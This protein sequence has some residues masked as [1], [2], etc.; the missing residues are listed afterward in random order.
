M[1]ISVAAVV[2]SL[3][4][5]GISAFG[6]GA[7]GT[8]TG[9]VTDSTGAVVPGA[10]IEVRN[11]ATGQVYTGASSGTGNFSIVQLPTGDYT[12]TVRGQGFKTFTH[13]N[14][15]LE[16]EAT[17]RQDATLQVGAASDT[18]TVAAEASLLTTES[19]EMATNVSVGSLDNLPILGIGPVNS[20][21]YGLRNPWNMM[22]FVGGVGSYVN[23]A[24]MVI[25]GLGGLDNLTEEMRIEGQDF[26]NHLDNFGTQ[27]NA[28]S[29]DAIQEV[30]VQTSN[31]AAEYGTAGAAVLNVTMKSGTNAFH[32]SAYDYFVN[33]DLNAG[34]PF[35][36]SGGPSSNPGG[37]L[38]KYRPRNRRND[39]GGTFGGPVWIPKIYN[40]R[41][42]TFFFVNFEQFR[43]T[44]G[45][46][47]GLTVPQPY[48]NA[49]DFSSISP[50]GTCSLCS[51]Y[52]IPTG[53]LGS[54]TAAKDPLGRTLLANTIYDPMT[55]GVVTSS[56]LGYA[57][58]F[59]NNQIPATRFDP[60]ALKLISLF[61]TPT[62]A[63]LTDDA[64]G[65]VPSQRVSEIPSF[66][67]DHS[68]SPKDKFSFYWQW[69]QTASQV[70]SPNGFADG[71][72][73]E[74]GEYIG[75]FTHVEISRLSYDRT[76]SPTLLLHIGVGNY[77][78]IMNLNAP[79]LSF[80]PSQFDLSG[81][82][83]HRQFPSFS[84]MSG[85]YGGMQGIGTVLQDQTNN[86]QE[87]PT[88]TANITKVKGSHT[89]KLG[90]EAYTQG[91]LYTTYAGVT[92]TTGTGP[93]MQPYTNTTSLNGYGTGFGYASFLLGDYTST[94]QSP[95]VD[96]RLGKAQYAFFAQDSWKVT[97]KLTVDYGLRYDLATAVRETYGRLGQ[98]DPNEVNT[99][100]GGH[101]GGVRYASNCGCDFYPG[102][103]PY[104]F[105]PR[106]GIA[107]QLDKKTVFRGGWG[108]VYQFG[109]DTAPGGIIS[110]AGTNTVPGINSFVNTQSPGFLLQPTWPVT[111][112]NIY[113][114]TLGTTTGTPVMADANMYR[115]PRLNQWSVGF[116]REITGSLLG[117][118]SYVGNR[119]V[120]LPGSLGLLNQISPSTYAEYGLYPYPGTGPC[121]TGGGVCANSSYNNYSDFLLLSQQVS[122]T[123]VEQ[124]MK[125]AGVGNGGLLLPYATASPTTS[126]TNA[127]RAYPQFPT[128]GPTGS[129]TGNERY[130]SLQAKVTKRFSHGLQ[131]DGNFT[132]EKSFTR[133]ARQDFWNPE[134]SQWALQ[135][136]P[137]RILNIT[138]VYT[139][140]KAAFF[141]NHAKFVNLIVKDWQISGS[142]RY[143]SGAFLAP[144]TSTTS[145]FLSSEDVMVPG[146]PLYLKNVNCKCINPYYDQVLN[147]AAWQQ[148][149]TNQVGPST[150]V[151]YENFRGPRHPSE[152]GSFG[153]NFRVKEKMN[154]QFRG[155]FVNIFNR[156]ELPSPGAANPQN[157]IVHNSQGI[158]TSGFGV[159]DAYQTPN[160]SNIFSG[161]TGTL[162][163]RFSF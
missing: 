59:V 121:T 108:V 35:S 160:T 133:A 48:M 28:P 27:Q 105:G 33:E 157:A 70:S 25:N 96:Y 129:A 110:T 119:Q 40:G 66:K 98:F 97:R 130:D 135:N 53:P 3:L 58:P 21:P 116:Q 114:T 80:D 104:A 161:R 99:Q 138:F 18:V 8:I 155:E 47:F 124:K 120:W 92:F 41:N 64:T 156:T 26:T 131:A 13:P 31:Y 17:L 115:P 22:A 39:Y 29:V 10:P 30:A 109:T 14:L 94:S 65:S 91:T 77:F 16:A 154:L 79:F 74:I 90:G 162:V 86:R 44:Y 19:G 107:Y 101:L 9:I 100:A 150:N 36:I 127:L 118:V 141:D 158:L 85:T 139:T 6:Q 81:F 151:L 128:L 56:G 140:P 93:T 143:Q 159:M 50:N 146:Q 55:R 20:S 34:D 11:A 63:N 75:T 136:L 61:P 37:D 134:S 51:T 102:A 137:P 103:Y 87:K 23:S 163:M 4:F 62:N 117:E 125:A 69:T 122:A 54:P 38:G 149:G 148:L 88:F 84:G 32:G 152:D 113:P 12:L 43:E 144:P 78:H 15:H 89:Y 145:N 72:P 153:R 71:L 24:T 76:I 132:W 147:P 83:I 46:S 1:K 126:L 68:L 49:G 112:P 82:E 42:K 67:I 123:A 7:T 95:Q 52:S 60:V 57:N 5:A 142:A 111:N 2:I 106:L 45:L 73:L